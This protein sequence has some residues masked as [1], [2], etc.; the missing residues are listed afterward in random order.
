LRDHSE[1]DDVVATNVHCRLAPPNKC[2]SRHFWVSA[3]SERRVLIE[4]WA[5]AESTLA[6]APRWKRSYLRIPYRDQSRLAANDAAFA[7]PSLMSWFVREYG[8]SWLLVER[9]DPALNRYAKLRFRA[10]VCSVYE[11]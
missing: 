8:V 5:Y 4:G 6:R 10:G 7:Q 1:P 11:V 2:D 3:Y 9:A